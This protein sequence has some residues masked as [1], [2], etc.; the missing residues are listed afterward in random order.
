V[1]RRFDSIE[2]KRVLA[3]RSWFRRFDQASGGLAPF[4]I[5]QTAAQN[6]LLRNWNPALQKMTCAASLPVATLQRLLLFAAGLGCAKASVDFAQ[7]VAA[8]ECKNA[9]WAGA[10][11]RG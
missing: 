2:T 3:L 5:D 10:T 1:E 8:A 11:L 6:E 4:E 7:P 9:R